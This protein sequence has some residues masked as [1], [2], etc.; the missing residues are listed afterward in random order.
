MRVRDGLNRDLVRYANGALTL[1][2]DQQKDLLHEAATAIRCYRQWISMSGTP[3]N[4]Q[5]TDIACQLDNYA[6]GLDF[7][8]DEETKAIMLEAADALRILRLMMGI[9]QEIL[10]ENDQ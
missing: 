7:R 1:G 8:Y 9:K 2:A 5:Q 3:A 4:D 6:D 10:E